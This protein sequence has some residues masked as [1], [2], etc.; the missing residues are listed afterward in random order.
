MSDPIHPFPAR[1]APEIALA[2]L[3]EVAPNSVVLDPMCG[4]GTVVREAANRHHTAIGRDVD[5]LAVLMTRVWTTP[6]DTDRLERS[7]EDVLGQ[8]SETNPD[9]L[10]LDWIDH[11]P[12]TESFTRFWFSD[13]QRIPLRQLA[14]AIHGRRG[15]IARALR[16]GLSKIIITKWGGASLAGD[17][18]HSRPHRVRVTNAYDVFQGF[19]K[20]VHEIADAIDTDPLPVRAIVRQGDATRI[21][22]PG[23]ETVDAVITSPPY[24]SGIDY[25][26]GHRMSLVWLGHRLEALRSIRSGS[27]GAQRVL[28][29]ESR[30]ISDLLAHL[31]G[32]GE[33]GAKDRGI[34]ARFALNVHSLL[35]RVVPMLKP[36]GRAVIVVGSSRVKGVELDNAGLVARAAGLV[37]L[38]Q[39]A[40]YEREIPANRRYL[41]PPG[42]ADSDFAARLG[43]ESVTTFVKPA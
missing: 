29:L 25:M 23:P 31:D 28:A 4:S 8:A 40:T 41:P 1:M 43:V 11:D 35:A 32:V 5:P 18:A 36:S 24:G 42:T 17:T 37:G 21:R 7:C 39:V 14:G 12:E 9:H 13:E 19:R 3:D 15:P 2:A 26:R 6:I 10:V 27:V 34:L 16:L 38:R 22:W 20:A 33:L 30:V